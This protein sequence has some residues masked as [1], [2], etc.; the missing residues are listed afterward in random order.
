MRDHV[1]DGE[2]VDATEE[3][4]VFTADEGGADGDEFLAGV[5]VFGCFERHRLNAHYYLC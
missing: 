3:G 4:E 1:Y 5:R 2:D